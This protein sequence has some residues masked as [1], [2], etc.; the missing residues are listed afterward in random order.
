MRY[1][2]LLAAGRRSIGV[3]HANNNIS[4]RQAFETLVG[5]LNGSSFPSYVLNGKWEELLF[6][7]S[8]II[9]WG[10]FP[11][12]VRVL[13]EVEQSLIACLLNV[14]HGIPRE[15]ESAPAIYLD[16]YLTKH[17]YLAAL[18][19]GGPGKDILHSVDSYA[20]ASDVGSWCIYTE[21]DNDVAVVAFRNKVVSE[22]Y[23]QVVE[24][25]KAEPIDRLIAGDVPQRP[26]F[27]MLV[28]EWRDGLYKNYKARSTAD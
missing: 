6:C 26:P 20:C 10:R 14:T 17:S 22:G 3:M 11:E 4:C 18:K 27:N 9:T 21:R 16:E 24:I 23:R 1:T 8:R 15:F 2:L 28:P 25:L 19:Q 12:V 13:L 7:E 5:L